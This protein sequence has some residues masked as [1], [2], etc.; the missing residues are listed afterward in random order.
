MDDTRQQG[1]GGREDE[2]TG[3]GPTLVKHRAAEKGGAARAS[4]IWAPRSWPSGSCIWI[5]DP[6]PPPLKGR[7]AGGGG[8]GSGMVFIA[9]DPGALI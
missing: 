9:V 4:L 6:P 1:K 8:G 5:P 7:K 3:G 2:M